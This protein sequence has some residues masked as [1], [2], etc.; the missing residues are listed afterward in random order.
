V[1]GK[2]FNRSSATSVREC[3]P[4]PSSFIAYITSHKSFEQF[5][6]SMA[7][8]YA[9]VATAL[10]ARLALAQ[11]VQCD[12]ET[13]PDFNDDCSTFSANWGLTV[14]ELINLNPGI[15]C[16]DLD[17]GRT[18][19]VVGTVA[20]STAAAPQKTSSTFTSTQ[21]GT[22]SVIKTTSSAPVTTQPTTTARPT[23]SST[24]ITTTS[25]AANQPQNSGTASNCDKFYKVASGDSCDSVT[26]KFGISVSQFRTWNTAV[27]SGL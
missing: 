9:V 14:Q 5:P 17:T 26:A 1:T 4:S 25:T 12:F 19:C 22:T 21:P 27:N 6:P 7:M 3:P 13:A 20:S 10:L 2:V 11:T 24:L 16:P 8:R 23:T 18:W 15:T